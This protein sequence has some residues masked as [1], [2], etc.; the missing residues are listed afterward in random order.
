MAHTT[1]S[2]QRMAYRDEGIGK[3]VSAPSRPSLGPMDTKK[4]GCGSGRARCRKPTAESEGRLL[5]S[6]SCCS[7]EVWEAV[8]F[9]A[10]AHNVKS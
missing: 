1:I 8:G 9:H 2:R 10:Y 4:T 3:P 6:G 5:R 7:A